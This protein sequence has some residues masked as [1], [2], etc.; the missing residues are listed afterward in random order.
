[1]RFIPLLLVLSAVP[2]LRAGE[3]DPDRDLVDRVNIAIEK[4][5]KYLR[6]H[7][8]VHDNWEA[9][10]PTGGATALVV[11]ALLNAG[12]KPTDSRI[13]AG[14]K[15]LR[16]VPAS[17]TYVVGLQTMA[18]AAAGEQQDLERIRQNV[19]WLL[20]AR[21]ETKEA[22]GWGYRDNDGDWVDQSN[23]QYALLGL[24]EGIAARVKVEPKD[25]EWIRNLYFK[26]QAK[27]GSWR[28]RVNAESSLSMTVAGACGLMIT[29]M[30]LNVGRETIDGGKVRGCG[31][32][33]DQANLVLAMNWIGKR[34]P[35]DQRDIGSLPHLYYSLYGIERLGRLSGQRFLA[36]KDWYRIGCEFLVRTQR[37]DGSWADGGGPGAESSPIVSTSFALLFLSKGRTPVLISKF[38]H[39]IDMDGRDWNND[40][41]DV[42]NLVEF[43]RKEL[44]RNQ[45]LAWQVFDP[46]QIEGDDDATV[47][48]LAE[49]LLQTPIVFIT[50][51][52][53]PHL[54]TGTGNLTRNGK[55]L[56]QYVD[57][58]G[59][60]YVEA[61]CGD[62]RFDRQIEEQV[63]AL[64]PY[65]KLEPLDES[66]PVWTASTKW[67]LS[68]KEFKLMGVLQGC[69]TPLIYSKDSLLCCQWEMNDVDGRGRRAFE[70]GGNIVAYA[71]GL[72]PPPVRGTPMHVIGKNVDTKSPPPGSFKVGQIDH[73]NN[74]QP[75]P[76]AMRN[77]MVA[78]RAAGLKDVDLETE[79]V[80]IDSKKQMT[81]YKFLYMHGRTPFEFK[82]DDLVD[83]RFN[84]ETHGLL[85]ADACCGSKIFDESFRALVKELFPDKKLEPI[86]LDDYL[87][88]A[89]LNGKQI[90]KVRCRRSSDEKE[91][92]AGYPEV[93][94]QLE[95]IRIGN[96]WAII[97]SR[98][99]IGCALEKHRSSNCLGHDHESAKRLAAAVVLYAL[100]P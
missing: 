5:Q 61:C 18:F 81:D 4:A 95:G 52:I 22:S 74:W 13:Q 67:K 98:Y 1:M 69:R 57:N 78:L 83:L 73:G 70:M 12:D 37:E 99:D 26:S 15:F 44:F 45:P 48:R 50:G 46:R 68:P 42:R 17:A 25:L 63:R 60:I 80:Y 54:T 16:T 24:H 40:R 33:K 9:E 29:G 77:L 8:T 21:K 53:D 55:I 51:H 88:S 76:N 32:Y 84:L 58:G 86:P 7:Q 47:R 97:Y 96:R 66:H 82:S 31:D 90:D 2:S 56:K 72:V 91:V 39:D 65:S 71:T 87:F 27:D 64:F 49:D 79:R 75:A 3:P 94:P 10:G 20:N 92:E 14:L 23:T 59:F 85:F 43:T 36:G 93:T 28:Y 30:D 41:Y 38:A 35:G 19:V 11:L 6:S 62:E 34:F 100:R 89:R